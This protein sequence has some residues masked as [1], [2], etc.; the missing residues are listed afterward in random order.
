MGKRLKILGGL[1]VS[2]HE[3]VDFKACRTQNALN[4]GCR[5]GEGV[6]DNEQHLRRICWDVPGQKLRY[7][8]TGY[9]VISVAAFHRNEVPLKKLTQNLTHNLIG[10]PEVDWAVHVATSR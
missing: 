7:A 5:I 9:D 8:T 10:G 3:D 1:S 6:R 4:A 2:V